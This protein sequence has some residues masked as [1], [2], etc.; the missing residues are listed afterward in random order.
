MSIEIDN[1]GHSLSEARSN[2]RLLVLALVLPPALGYIIAVERISTLLTVQSRRLRRS[3]ILR[4]LLIGAF[5]NHFLPTS[6]GGD[7]YV[8]R[9][10]SRH[11]SSFSTAFAAVVTGR[12]LGLATHLGFAGIGIL[13]S[14]ENLKDTARSLLFLDKPASV[15]QKSLAAI[16]PLGFL[17]PPTDLCE[18]IR[19][20]W[21]SLKSPFQQYRKRPDILLRAGILT[22]GLQGLLV[23]QYWLFSR[24]LNAGIEFRELL[25]A[26]PLVTLVSMIPITING[27]G[28]REWTMIGLSSKLDYSRV[29]AAMMVWMFLCATLIYASIGAILFAMKATDAD[30]QRQ[31]G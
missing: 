1:L 3:L 22:L 23:F 15:D 13:W 14:P 29:D 20:R 11:I 28:L 30:K 16:A 26:V 25:V 10:L 27:M 24:V 19:G 2:W 17:R 8:V 6:L 21:R 18:W 5:L 9:Q 4:F 7:A 31:C 12:L